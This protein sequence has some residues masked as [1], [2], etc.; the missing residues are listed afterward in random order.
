MARIIYGSIVTQISG[1]IGGNTFA[2]NANGAYMRKRTRPAN[3][4]TPNQQAVR[5]T[6]GGVSSA[7]SGLNQEQR[8]TWIE[9]ANLFPYVD[10][11]GQTQTYTG[12]QLFAKLNNSL[13]A[14]GEGLLQVCPDPIQVDGIGFI[15]LLQEGTSETLTV[16]A[17]NATLGDGVVPNGTIMIIEATRPMSS[18]TYRP[19]NQDFR[20]IE[21]VPEG[22]DISSRL[23]T[24]SYLSVYPSTNLTVRQNIF[25]RLTFVSTP[26]GQRSASVWRGVTFQP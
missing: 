16:K 7:W 25:V 4:N 26:T 10:S 3:P 21:V 5:S 2:M 15:D 19:K 22:G 18:G 13:A 1:S 20:Q 17:E 9:K 8:E 24:D 6:F 14:V 12:R 11:L 23:I